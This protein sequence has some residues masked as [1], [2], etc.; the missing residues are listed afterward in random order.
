ASLYFYCFTKLKKI[1]LSS[2]QEKAYHFLEGMSISLNHSQK[3]LT[4][5]I[6]YVMLLID[7][8]KH[9]IARKK[10]NDNHRNHYPD[11][12]RHRARVAHRR[13]PAL[14]REESHQADHL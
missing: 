12:R 11:Q 3:L 10:S 9:S 7:V 5:F 8:E 4:Y 14:Q 1:H 13:R 6:E 2:F